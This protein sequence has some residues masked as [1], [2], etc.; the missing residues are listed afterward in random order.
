[1]VDDFLLDLFRQEV[2]TNAETLNRGLVVLEREPGNARM[3]EPLM[4]RPLD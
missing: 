2:N 1:M 4:H 3:I